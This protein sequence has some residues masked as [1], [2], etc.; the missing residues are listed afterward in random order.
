MVRVIFGIAR[1]CVG[2]IGAWWVIGGLAGIVRAGL[3][4]A[5]GP[6]FM[7]ALFAFFGFCLAYGAFVR[8][9]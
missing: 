7:A 3:D 6:A 8:F 1:G 5:I 2:I 9:P 4:G